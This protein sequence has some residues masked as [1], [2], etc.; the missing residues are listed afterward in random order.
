MCHTFAQATIVIIS[1]R[2]FLLSLCLLGPCVQVALPLNLFAL[3]AMWARLADVTSSEV[4]LPFSPGCAHTLCHDAVCTYS[5][6]PQAPERDAHIEQ[7]LFAFAV[8]K[9]P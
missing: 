1:I 7:C 2:A 6:V 8:F 4:R 3:S 5:R 9:L